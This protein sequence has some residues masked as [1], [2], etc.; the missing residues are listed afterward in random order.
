MPIE[1]PEK[2]KILPA[3]TIADAARYI[4]MKPSTVR[5]WLRGQRPIFKDAKGLLS[6]MDLVSAHVLHT[7]R[8]GY[9]I[10]MR[11]VRKAADTLS[12]ISGGLTY[13]AHR[14]FY[15]DDL[16]L[17]LILD[18]RLVSLSEGGQ[19][20]DKEIIKQGLRQLEYGKDG[21][22]DRFFPK[23]NGAEQSQFAI[24]P[25]VNFGK[26][27]LVRSG[28]GADAIRDRFIAGEKIVD[29]AED[30]GAESDEIEEAIRWHERLAA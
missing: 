5:E 20:V 28:I 26:L 23:A 10:P 9:H 16:N 12:K 2:I 18:E 30:Y 29:L 22:T 3:Y 19:Y 21:F 8:K 15:H 4:G 14:D 11:Q 13:L 1:Q 24:N 17:F 7:I 27:S 25:K 6:F